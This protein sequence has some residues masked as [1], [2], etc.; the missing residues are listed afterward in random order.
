MAFG[1]VFAGGGVRGAY[2]IGMWKALNEMK[3]DVCAVSGTSIGAINGALFVQGML[4]TAEKLWNDIE[5]S[6]IVTLPPE[7]AC[8]KNLFGIKNI[9]KIY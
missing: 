3:I 6:D 2:H 7:L 4:E 1:L 5:L 9:V 8:E